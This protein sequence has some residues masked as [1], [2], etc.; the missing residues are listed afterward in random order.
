MLYNRVERGRQS[1][2]TTTKS[3]ESL[4]LPH[5][6]QCLWHA[7]CLLNEWIYAKSEAQITIA[8]ESPLLGKMPPI[9]NPHQ[10]PKIRSYKWD[11][12]SSAWIIQIS[13]VP[14]TRISV[15][16]GKPPRPSLKNLLSFYV[17]F[18]Q[19]SSIV[20]SRNWKVRHLALNPDFSTYSLCQL[21]WKELPTCFDSFLSSIKKTNENKSIYLK[22]SCAMVQSA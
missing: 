18:K 6:W 7:K 17:P 14:W 9:L 2:K 16:L 20:K 13:Q 15:L 1:F 21:I 19:Y 10:H 8:S 4:N 11:K 5:G 22:D 3:C 12:N